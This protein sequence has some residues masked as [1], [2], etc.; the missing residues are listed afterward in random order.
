MKFFNECKTAEDLKALYKK[1]ARK[2][3]PDLGGDLETMKQ[4]NA[5]YDEMYEKLKNIHSTTD[6]KTYEKTT[7]STTQFGTNK[8]KPSGAVNLRRK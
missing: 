2:N 8:N 1:L 5:E 4:I 7:T 6:G 3:H